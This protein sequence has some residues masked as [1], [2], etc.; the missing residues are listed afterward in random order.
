MPTSFSRRYAERNNDV[1]VF[2]K[3]VENEFDEEFRLVQASLKES[4]KLLLR[5]Y[6]K[7]TH[8]RKSVKWVDN[9][10]KKRTSKTGTIYEKEWTDILK[11]VLACVRVCVRA[12]L[13]ARRPRREFAVVR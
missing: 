5:A 11:C 7:D 9:L 12:C 8:K 10:L 3:I 2:K 1:L 4:V 13:C 6:L